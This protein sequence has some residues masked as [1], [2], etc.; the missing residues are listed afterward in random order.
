M[1]APTANNLLLGKGGVYFDRFDSSNNKTGEMHL[2]NC[3]VFEVTPQVDVK[4]KASS[5]KATSDLYKEVNNGIRFD[6]KIDGS[7]LNAENMALLIFGDKGALTQTTGTVSGE[8][9]ATAAKKGRWYDTDY[10]N[11][12]S[13]SVYGGVSGTTLKTLN[14]DYTLDT[15]TGRVYV[16]PGGTIADGDVIKV[17]YT[18]T[19]ITLTRVQ[20]KTKKYIEGFLRF[21]GDPC[22]GDRYEVQVWRVRISSENSFNLIND[23]FSV[24][25]LKGAVINDATN[26]PT[27]PYFDVITTESATINPSQNPNTKLILNFEGA[28]NSTTFTDTSQ[29]NHT[30][31]IG[32][33]T[34]TITT[35]VKPFGTS[36]LEL[37][38]NSGEYISSELSSDFNLT[39]KQRFTLEFWANLSTYNQLQGSLTIGADH[40]AVAPIR[41]YGDGT[42]L[43]GNAALSG[44]QTIALSSGT[45]PTNNAWNHFCVVGDGT[46]IKVY[47]NGQNNGNQATHPNW[48][49]GNRRVW[50]GIGGQAASGY[51]KCV[52]LTHDVLYTA[53]FTP[54]NDIFS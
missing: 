6:F 21:I 8:T 2:G 25:S 20:A 7:E 10:R 18:Y 34:P 50:V 19:S 22:A 54:P 16:V 47:V 12:S 11:I 40:A 46:N 39:G 5:L 49:S 44:W 38:Y 27:S 9:V 32:S 41:F 13:V 17:N 43:V 1:P 53:N 28:N 51:Y 37:S 48:T 26:H 30:M 52:R 4:S 45:S 23:D 42:I 36:S 14:T 35:S 33:G 29:S 3:D 24:W 15:V 31:S